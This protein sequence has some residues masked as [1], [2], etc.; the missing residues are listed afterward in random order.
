MATMNIQSTELKKLNKL[1]CPS[2]DASVTVGRK[3]KA[4][5]SGEGGR[6]LGGKVDG[7]GSSG[8][9]RGT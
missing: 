6:N 3:K 9:K 4:I 2:E 5:T 1:K 7:V 8:G